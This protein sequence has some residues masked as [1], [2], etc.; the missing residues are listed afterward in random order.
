M[1]QEKEKKDAAKLQNKKG[2]KVFVTV[3]EIGY[4]PDDVDKVRIN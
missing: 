3:D 2:E 4:E 1:R